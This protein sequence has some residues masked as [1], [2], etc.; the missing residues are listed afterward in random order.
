MHELRIKSI[1]LC[2]VGPFQTLDVMFAPNA[3]INLICGDNGIGKTTLLEALIASVS[4]GTPQRLRRRA[5]SKK[6]R[7][8]VEF[9]EDGQIHTN[10]TDISGFEPDDQVWFQLFPAFSR[11]VLN[12][13]A[14][15]DFG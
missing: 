5:G 10:S 6:G 4:A 13:R 3:G 12:I 9:V 2:D 15:R 8:T 14:S 7:L 1:S 11:S